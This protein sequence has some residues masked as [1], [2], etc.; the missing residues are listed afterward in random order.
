MDP[1]QFQSLLNDFKDKSSKSV[2]HLLDQL[3]T[4]RT[5]RASPALVDTLKVEYYGTLTPLNQMAHISVPEPRQLMVKPFDATAI[6]EIERAILKSDLGLT[7]ASDGKV[8][9]LTMPPLSVEQRKKLAAKVKDI[10]EQSRI[11]L[12]N[13]RRE[14]NKKVDVLKNHG[15]TEDQVK[16][17]HDK[18]QEE[19]KAAEHQVDDILKKKTT[20]IME[21]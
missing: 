5:G 9:R 6:K 16:K 10:A 3:R 14:V 13:E 7:P 20:E 17:F 21:T 19:L 18:V 4:I 11:A 15:L 8:V 12:R 1:A 2:Q